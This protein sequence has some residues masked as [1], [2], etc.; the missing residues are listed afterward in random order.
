MSR[1]GPVAGVIAIGVLVGAGC[2]TSTDLHG[3]P[4]SASGGVESGPQSGLWG[5]GSSG[6]TGLHIGCIRGRRLV[7]LVSVRNQTNRTVTLL[8]GGGAQPL[9]DVLER[10]AVQIRLAPPPPSGDIVVSGLRAWNARNS[11]PAAIPAGRSANVQSN[12]LMRNCSSL[13]TDQ[14]LVLNRSVTLAY[15]VGGRRGTQQL[16]VPAAQIILKRGPLHP[17]LPINHVG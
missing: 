17:K 3:V 2:G 7:A 10:V 12:F 11:P 14:A 9:A 16:A 15:S 1:G 8:G 13:S 6:P 4:F 5:D